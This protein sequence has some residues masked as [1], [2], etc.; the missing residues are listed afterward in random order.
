MPISSVRGL[1]FNFNS[2]CTARLFAARFFS[3]A[4]VESPGQQPIGLRV[5][6]AQIE[7][8]EDAAELIAPR[9]EQFRQSFAEFAR[10]DLSGIGGTDGV[11]RVGIGDAAR[12]PVDAARRFADEA[13]RRLIESGKTEQRI[14]A[15]ALPVR[16]CEW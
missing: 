14:A 1:R 15:R 7:P 2:S 10:E 8:V 6:F 4:A 11:D 3:E 12:Q 16:G 5:P 9:V 13:R